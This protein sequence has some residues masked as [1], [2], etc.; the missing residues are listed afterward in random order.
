MKYFG[1][2]DPSGGS[3]DSMTLAI[4]RT[5]IISKKAVLVGAWE[6]RAPF[7]PD[8]VTEEFAEILR[9]YRL[10]V[11]TGDRY[12]AEWVR[13]RFRTHG[14]TYVTSEK[15]KSDIFLEFLAVVNSDRVRMPNNKR[16]RA[17]LVSLERRT[18]RSGKDTVDHPPGA[19]DDLANCVAGALV[20]AA[21][22]RKRTLFLP[23]VL[24]IQVNAPPPSSSAWRDPRAGVDP[25]DARV[26]FA[27]E[28]WHRL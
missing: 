22:H 24:D 13:E 27:G 20:L 18:S 25:S 3:S 9:G 23:V 1:F 4:A 15:T 17:Q 6:R 21:V 11:V 14:I 10:S 26:D 7:N 8:V 19:H 12:S 28:T 16:L 5:S 2:C